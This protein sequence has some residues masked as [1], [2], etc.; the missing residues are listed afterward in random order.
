MHVLAGKIAMKIVTT[1]R[2]GETRK[3]TSGNFLS[4]TSVIA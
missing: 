4:K 2:I 1:Q 3:A